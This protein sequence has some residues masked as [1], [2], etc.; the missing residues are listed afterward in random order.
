MLEKHVIELI[1]GSVNTK[2]DRAVLGSILIA[3]PASASAVTSGTI[4]AAG[5][6]FTDPADVVCTPSAGSAVVVCSSIKAVTATVVNGG[7][8]GFAINDTITLSNGV[9]LTVA[10]VS[11]GVVLTA[12]VTTPGA[13]TAA[14]AANPVSQT[15]TSGAGVGTTTWN[16]A[17]GLNALKV[18]DSGNG[19]NPTWTVTDSTGAGSGATMTTAQGGSSNPVFVRVANGNIPAVCVASASADFACNVYVSDKRAGSVTFAVAPIGGTTVSAGN[20]NAII[21]A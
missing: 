7:T 3:T 17:Y 10:T 16:L 20:L 4:T 8:S 12:N 21:Q 15:A 6:G 18:L 1:P 2:G 19:A 11:G 9:V 14:V 13:F 5:T